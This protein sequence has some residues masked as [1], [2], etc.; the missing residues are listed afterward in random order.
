MILPSAKLFLHYFCLSQ[1]CLLYWYA[2]GYRTFGIC[3]QEKCVLQMRDVL[4]RNKLI[5]GGEDQVYRPLCFCPG[6]PRN[7]AI[8][9]P[10]LGT[11]GMW[12]KGWKGNR[13]GQALSRRLLALCARKQFRSLAFF[14]SEIPKILLTP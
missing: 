10:L 12:G 1:P 7:S 2:R 8:H 9:T 4:A 14:I 11:S 3:N 6:V 5:R 13:K